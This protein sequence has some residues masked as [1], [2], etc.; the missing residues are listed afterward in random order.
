M[1][2]VLETP[3]YWAF[4]WCSG[5]AL[6]QFLLADPSWVAGKTVVDLG[7]GSGVA[8]I[9][10]AM[11]GASRVVACDTDPGARVAT[12]TNANLNNVELEVTDVLP[13]TADM[14][15]MADVLYDRRNLPLLATAQTHAAEILVADSRVTTL[16]ESNY[17]KVAR[18][19]ALTYPNLGEFDEFKTA[20]LFH[21]SA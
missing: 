12:A 17:R 11:A 16:P 4:C 5:L 7:S 20:H 21:W 19:D 2:A 10:A 18:I 14:L 8:A 1:D 3:A 9:A 6:A 13:A 15:L